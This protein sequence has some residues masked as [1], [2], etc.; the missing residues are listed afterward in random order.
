VERRNRRL[1]DVRAPALQR[2]C[3]IEGRAPAGDSIWAAFQR[4]LS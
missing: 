4:D 2:E 1:H 3:P